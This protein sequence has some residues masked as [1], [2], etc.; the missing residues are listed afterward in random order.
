MPDDRNGEQQVPCMPAWPGTAGNAA[1][2]CST[3]GESLHELL[4]QRKLILGDLQQAGTA[5]FVVTDT[6]MA[7]WPAERFL[8]GS[9]QTDTGSQPAA[10][11]N[12]GCISWAQKLLVPPQHSATADVLRV[13]VRF[14]CCPDIAQACCS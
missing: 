7:S 13:V 9:A 10:V 1:G 8:A 3:A 2:C 5:N 14:T 4:N 6:T 11:Q 12:S